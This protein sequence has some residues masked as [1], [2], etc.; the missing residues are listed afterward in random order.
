M[1]LVE[2]NYLVE[3]MYLFH[4]NIIRYLIVTFSTSLI[5]LDFTD[6]HHLCTPRLYLLLYNTYFTGTVHWE[7]R[8][9]CS[10]NRTEVSAAHAVFIPYRSVR[11]F[12]QLEPSRSFW[13]ARISAA[14]GSEE[15]TPGLRKA[16]FI[17][18]VRGIYIK[19]LFCET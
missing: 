14:P 19:R 6:H 2:F 8:S 3:S 9:T 15:L 11:C 10:L 5:Y 1:P 12:P 18:I 7:S 16:A 13:T 4:K 17:F